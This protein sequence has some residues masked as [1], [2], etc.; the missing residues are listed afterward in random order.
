MPIR[1]LKV[2]KAKRRTKDGVPMVPT[3]IRLPRELQERLQAHA[4]RMG[5]SVA[6]LIRIACV[7]WLERHEK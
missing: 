2:W 3:V 7:E 5:I 1:Y 6:S 4:T